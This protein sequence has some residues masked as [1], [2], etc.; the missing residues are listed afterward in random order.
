MKGVLCEKKNQICHAKRQ[1]FVNKDL[2]LRKYQ[3]I[4]VHADSGNRFNRHVY[5]Y[6]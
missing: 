2:A 4:T 6:M 5:I 3:S 1:T